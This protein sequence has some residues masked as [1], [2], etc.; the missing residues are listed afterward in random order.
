VFCPSVT[1]AD[2]VQRSCN[3]VN[4]IIKSRFK[5]RAIQK[6]GCW[7]WT[8]SVDHYGYGYVSYMTRKLKAHRVA[9]ELFKQ[10]IPQGLV[11]D[12]L[13][14]NR[15]CVNPEHLEP[16]TIGENVSRGYH[17]GEFCLHEHRMTPDNTGTRYAY[18]KTYPYCM[19]CKRT[20]ARE[21]ARRK[22][23]LI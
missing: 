1:S 15:K 5:L 12:H 8:G 4:E 21:R 7:E 6:D 19:E 9:Y 14:R 22:R 13:C 16:V 3:V 10:E 2:R 23:G 11:I 17:L 20:Q 18:G